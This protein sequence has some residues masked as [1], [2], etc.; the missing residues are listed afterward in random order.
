M[1]VADDVWCAESPTTQK[2][3]APVKKTLFII[4]DTECGLVPHV[5]LVEEERL[6]KLGETQEVIGKL[7]VE[8]DERVIKW[9]ADQFRSCCLPP[10]DTND[11][12]TTTVTS[13]AK[14]PVY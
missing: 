8:G 6:E 2:Q 13:T 9:L 12:G 14:N 3:Q 4:D 1:V 11:D 10:I 5:Y 7:V